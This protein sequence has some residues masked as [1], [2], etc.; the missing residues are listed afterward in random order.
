MQNSFQI[1]ARS[2]GRASP[3][4]IEGRHMTRGEPSRAHLA[5]LIEHA[6]RAMRRGGRYDAEGAFIPD[7][8]APEIAAVNGVVPL[9]ASLP[10]L[11]DAAGFVSVAPEYT[12]GSERVTV[13]AAL[14]Q[15]SVCLASGAHLIE[16]PE[17]DV[18]ADP[19]G[20]PML[21]EKSA[22][23]DVI[24][25]AGFAPVALTGTG[26]DA[27]GDAP[28]S[29]SPVARALIDRD[30]LEQIAFRVELPR[31]VLRDFGAELLETH[32]LAAIVSGAG[33]ALDGVLL[34]ALATAP[35]LAADAAPHA[36]CGRAGVRW[37]ELKAVIGQNSVAPTVDADR[38]LIGGVHAEHTTG[39]PHTIA[40]A[41]G[42][43]A[44]A[45]SPEIEVL[46]ERHGVAGGLVLTAW[47][48]AQA[49]IP[50]PD[51]FAAVA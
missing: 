39:A 46:I 23:L 24:R 47:M 41:W 48:D 10:D 44:V 16:L 21:A 51:F 20:M 2:T 35:A 50:D 5:A 45:V 14:T 33:A 18:A 42:R 34:R 7:P 17:L 3:A 38:L 37:S 12:R 6:S 19:E 28:A 49:L 30:A 8:T 13:R 29:A 43:C 26:A 32:L 22:G 11:I 27:E 25:P 36:I 15:S 1:G 9:Y 40:G 4:A 31:S